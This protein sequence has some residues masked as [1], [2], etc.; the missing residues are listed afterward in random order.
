MHTDITP[1][2][3]RRQVPPLDLPLVDGGRFVLAEERPARFTLLVVYRGL[4]C[5]LCK[6]QLRE[7]EAKLPAFGER[8]VGVVAISSDDAER[9]ER[10]RADWGLAALRVAYG[11]D[12]ETARRFGLYVSRGRGP[13]SLGI[14]EPALFVEPAL[15]LVRED[16][17]LYFGSVQT[18]PFARPHLSDVIAAIDFVVAKH[19][20]ARGEVERVA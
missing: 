7:L 14:E 2:L 12:L 4:H 8:G 13:T 9:A 11:L 16:G 3:P 15:F 18:M 10:T 1:L 19:Y 17:T 5:P 20:P 6:A